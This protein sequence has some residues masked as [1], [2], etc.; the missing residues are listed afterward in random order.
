MSDSELCIQTARQ[1]DLPALMFALQA[2]AQ[3]LGDPFEATTDTVSTALF[4]PNCFAMAVLARRREQTLGIALGAPLFSTMGGG[5]VLYVSDLWVAPAA[6]RQ[7][8]GQKLLAA[9][10]SEGAA[11]WQVKS[12]KLTVYADNAQALK[13]YSEL[14]FV[15]NENDRSA[16]L[17]AAAARHWHAV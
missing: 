6:R 10:L 5:T 7:S 4:G 3:D 1:Q 13:F 14:G 11:R 12:I 15:L 8:L 2:L 16:V 17:P 9:A